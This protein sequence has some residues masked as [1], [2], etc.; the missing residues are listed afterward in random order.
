MKPQLKKIN[1]MLRE[2]I[3]ELKK[4]KGLVCNE[5]TL[6][7]YTQSHC[8][9]LGK[10]KGRKYRVDGGQCALVACGPGETL[11]KTTDR[12]KKDDKK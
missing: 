9:E 6:K 2:S 4:R 1:Q 3:F 7:E 11:D 8:D 10:E 12:C 5:C